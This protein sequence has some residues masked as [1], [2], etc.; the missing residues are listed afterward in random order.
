MEVE[1]SSSRLLADFA[2]KIQSQGKHIYFTGTDDKFAFRRY[3]MKECP[4]LDAAALLQFSD[5]DRAL[6]WCEDALLREHAAFP[7][8]EAETPLED[9][10]LCEGLS[11][12]EMTHLYR[13]GKRRTF[14]PGEVIFRAGDPGDSFYMILSGLVDILI[15]VNGKRENRLV[16]IR[17]GMSFG[18]FAMVTEQARSA[19]ARAVIETTCYEISCSEI[20]EDLK[21]KILVTVAKELSRRLS[22]EAREMQV[23]GGRR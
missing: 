14:P 19:E 9:Q 2:V 10:Y 11:A 17:S 23:L 12:E 1:S 6:E 5:K 15:R 20:S 3:L 8:S 16:T 21:T 4:G 18:E 7:E 13:I 22:K